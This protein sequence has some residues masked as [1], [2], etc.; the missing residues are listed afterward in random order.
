MSRHSLFRLALVAALSAALPAVPACSSDDTPG[1]SNATI[2]DVVRE[3]DVTEGQLRRVL[4]NEAQDWAWA[5][6]Q[7]DTPVDGSVLPSDT[8]FEF[9]W[10]SD[11]TVDPPAA[12]AT[13][14]LQM[15][16]LLV[17]STRAQPNLLRVFSTLDSY[18]PD[19]AAWEALKKAGQSGAVTLSLTS[20]TLL[21]DELV[22]DGGPFIGEALSF[23]I[24]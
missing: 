24:E 6:G 1:S 20:A 21:G 15:V 5:G 22:D 10:D 3:G 8:P 23:T 11:A 7:F 4:A 9:R 12:G 13:N 2:V 17:F 18:T 19:A 16:H 14:D